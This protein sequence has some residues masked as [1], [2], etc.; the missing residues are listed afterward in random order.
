MATGSITK[1]AVDA[2]TIG[3][4]WDAGDGALKGFGVLATPSGVKSFI[5]DYRIAGRK[6]RFTI[7]R[8]GALTVDQARKR[9]HELA[10]S[11]RRGI[12]PLDARDAAIE[13]AAKAKADRV[14]AGARLSALHFEN[15]A[16]DYLR[17]HSVAKGNR[18]R[19]V[20]FTDSHIRLH[21][22]PTLGA[23]PLTAIDRLTVAKLMDSLASQSVR[24][25]AF[26]TLRS[27]MNWATGRG[28]IETNPLLAMNQPTPVA[29]RD[30]VLS[31]AELISVWNAAA[32]MGTGW[33]G[34]YRLLI[35]TGARRDEVSGMKW[36]EL[37]RTS[38]TWTLPASRSKNGT[39]H[40]VPLCSLALAEIDQAALVWG[41]GGWPGLGFVNTTSGK[42]GVGGYS[43]AKRQIDEII[44]AN[45]ARVDGWRVHDLRRTFAT[46]QQKLGTRFEV[47]EALL[48]HI[49]GS[50][51]G[52]AGVYQRHDWAAE[53]RSAME[54]WGRHL[55][56]LI[57]GRD[58][59]AGNVVQ[60]SR[61]G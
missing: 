54:A 56:G 10:D 8:Y 41:E 45:G 17:L 6:R 52:V 51:S 35:A 20:G 18:P 31:D 40:I 32:S 61:A 13:L 26:A 15:V 7:G 43:K 3:K 22:N 12:D 38:A 59:S 19:S 14:E 47:C 30:R 4:L 49:S 9:V 60:M 48:N 33:R 37:D 24:R 39:A 42:A 28:L 46:A 2:L 5:F 16:A 23:K 53:K 25:G 50:K 21:L 44:L 36:D 57:E 1:R 11:V 58:A 34:F 29:A 55:S 27:V